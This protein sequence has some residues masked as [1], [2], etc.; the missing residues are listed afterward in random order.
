MGA[1][2]LLQNLALLSVGTT[3]KTGNPFAAKLN[4]SLWTALTTGESG[5]GDLRYTLNK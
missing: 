1:I 3:V 2:S 4:K 5:S